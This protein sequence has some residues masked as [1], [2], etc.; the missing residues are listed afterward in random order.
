MMLP[1]QRRVKCDPEI[2]AACRWADCRLVYLYVAV[3]LQLGLVE[4][5]DIAV[6]SPCEFLEYALITF[7]VLFNPPLRSRA[8]S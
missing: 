3:N 8:G 4:A 2:F 1:I 5:S 7:V 6:D